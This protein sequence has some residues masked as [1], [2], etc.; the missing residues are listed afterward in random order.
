MYFQGVPPGTTRNAEAEKMRDDF[1]V[2]LSTEGISDQVRCFELIHH[3]QQWQKSNR[4]EQRKQAN[5]S[6][7]LKENRKK[8]LWLLNWR[9]N[10]LSQTEKC[11]LASPKPKISAGSHFKK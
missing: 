2:K 5:Q 7:W 11:S 6:R 8:L 3:L 10:A 1:I 9:K 4:I